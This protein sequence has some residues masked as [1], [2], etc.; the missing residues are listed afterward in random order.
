[1]WTLVAVMLLAGSFGGVINYF[2][3]RTSDP[4][5]TSILKSIIIGIGASFLVPLFLN[6]ISSNLIESIKGTNDVPGDNSKLL[7]LAGFCLIAAISSSAFIQTLSDRVLNEARAAKKQAE[8][9]KAEAAQAKDEVAEVQASV[10]PIINKETEPELA[11]E[12]VGDG[13][14]T[15][16][17]SDTEKKIL[18]AFARSTYTH[19]SLKGL[20]TDTGIPEEELHSLLA[21]LVEKGLI[22]AKRESKTGPKWFMTQRGLNAAVGL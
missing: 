5:N 9:A 17:L 13:A 12:K 22:A 16:G 4:E 14:T 2:L 10:D 18:D 11:P 3:T 6:M 1:M 7:V 21:A 8:E 19:R 15:E 20:S